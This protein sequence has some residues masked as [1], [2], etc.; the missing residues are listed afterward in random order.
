MI[1]SGYY[2]IH[3]SKL[4]S[5]ITN[6][7]WGIHNS[8]L[9]KYRGGSP[10][11]W[12]IINNEKYLGSSFFKFESGIDEGPILDQF[13]ISNRPK[14]S[15]KKALDDIE[16]EWKKRIPI[17][18]KKFCNG[19]I[20]PKKQ[21]HSEATYCAQRY[22][23][24]GKVNWNQK[25]STID[26]FVN[27]QTYPYPKAFFFL[28]KKKIK[29]SKHSIDERKVSGTI[30]QV[31]EIKKNYVT[32]CCGENTIIRLN[33]LEIEGKVVPASEMFLSI[34]ERI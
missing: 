2:R 20:K 3:P 4:F 13:T 10:L 34:K 28:N 5:Q 32:I 22:E 9:P 30:G 27:A 24:D 18:W 1:V 8:K 23:F 19:K 21:N 33:K 14:L 11:V 17:L 6:A 12:Q 29:I 16:N 25:A 7:V 15:I 31:F 26:S